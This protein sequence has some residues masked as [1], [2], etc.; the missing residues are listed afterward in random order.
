MTFIILFSSIS[1]FQ[2]GE[3][4]YTKQLHDSIDKII[5]I[6]G[7]QCSKKDKKNIVVAKVLT[8]VS[9][10]KVNLFYSLEYEGEE[11]KLNDAD[12]ADIQILASQSIEH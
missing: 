12:K 7:S 6:Y 2:V 5:Q 3:S 4:V 9:N 1:Y 8:I 10:Q 11:N